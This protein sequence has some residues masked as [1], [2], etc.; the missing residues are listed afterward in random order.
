LLARGEVAVWAGGGGEREAGRA[1]RSFKYP[2]GS[3]A[4]A[5]TAASPGANHE[6]DYSVGRSVKTGERG[7]SAPFV[8]ALL[9][10]R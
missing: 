8:A 9:H 4:E 6:N 5:F 7:R 1:W 10:V 3:E 2:V